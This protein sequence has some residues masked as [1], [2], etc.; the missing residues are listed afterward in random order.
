MSDND[1][2]FWVG[3]VLGMVLGAVTFFIGTM[4]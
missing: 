1:V 2:N 4:F 3:F